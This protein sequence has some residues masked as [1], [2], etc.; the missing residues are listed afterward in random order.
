MGIQ[1][2]DLS[3]MELTIEDYEEEFDGVWRIFNGR[4]WTHACN[5]KEQ[6]ISRAK[7]W[8]GTH[9]G[10]ARFNQT[11]GMNDYQEVESIG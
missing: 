1:V 4:F 7:L 3:T 5:T 8:D 6:A 2:Y 11:T 9:V 10:K